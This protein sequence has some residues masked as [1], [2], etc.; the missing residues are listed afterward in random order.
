M[1]G[2]PHP[3]LANVGRIRRRRPAISGFRLTGLTLACAASLSACSFVPTYHAPETPKVAAFTGATDQTL[4]NTVPVRS[5]WW[6][7]FNDPALDALVDRSL[8]HNMTLAAAVAN[9]RLSWANAEQSGAALFPT[10]ALSGTFARGNKPNSSTSN[11]SQGVYGVASYEFDFWGKNRATARS[12]QWLAHASE[13]DRDTAALTLTASVVNGYFLTQSLRER[14]DIARNIAADAEHTLDLLIAQRAA[15][16][17]TTLQVEQQRTAV[18]NFNA[19]IYAL[20]QQYDLSIHALA[21]LAGAAPE[22][23]AVGDVPLR[24]VPVPVVRSM[25]PTQV[26]ESRPDI[27]SQEAQLR[28]A[29]Q[30]IG[31]ARAAFLP[32]IPLTL[33]GGFF[34]Q[35][36]AQLFSRTFGTLAATLNAPIFDGG[37]LSGQ[38]H[39]SHATADVDVANYKQTVLAALQDVEDSL[40]TAHQQQL[41][42]EQA[43]TAADAAGHAVTLAKAQFQYGTSDFLNVLVT[44]SALYQAQDALAQARLARLQASVGIFRA[45][46]GGYG[47]TEGPQDSV[48]TPTSSPTTPGM[49]ALDSPSRTAGLPSLSASP[50]LASAK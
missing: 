3:L 1:S 17:A 50:A 49:A 6:R 5:G 42:E 35:A 39:A 25:V 22:G 46:G 41:V 12:A 44:Q 10:V 19:A 43:S 30:S 37:V 9:V 16:V 32:N 38:L 15:G 26:L 36:A 18:A 11:H 13:F 33:N 28:A 14:T 2:Q 7:A 45:F 23:F 20:Q 48:A 40:S 47:I 21:V 24:G 4:A 34:S 29:Y 27:R 31:A 8:A